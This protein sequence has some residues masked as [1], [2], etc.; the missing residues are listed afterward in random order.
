MLK[1]KPSAEG[2]KPHKSEHQEQVALFEWAQYIPECKWMFA[3]PNQGGKGKQA[4][5]RGQQMKREGAKSGVH[6]IFLP[7]P[8]GEYHGLWIEMKVGKNKLSPNQ[9][10][11]AEDMESKNYKTATAYSCEEAVAAVSCYLG[12]Y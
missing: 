2:T 8:A 5:I 12:L 6:D 7:H 3:I 10:A 11:F 4:I 1:N 9:V